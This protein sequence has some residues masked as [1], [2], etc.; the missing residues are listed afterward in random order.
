MSQKAA[1]TCYI[2]VNGNQL[3]YS[4]KIE[5]PLTDVKRESIVPGFFKETEMVPYVK[6]D[7]VADPSLNYESLK[8][9]G[10]TIT[11][12]FDNSRTYVLSDAYLTGEPNIND[13]GVVSLQFDGRIGTFQ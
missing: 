8:Q 7:I 6:C 9:V 12:D 3:I 1:G 11:V 4:G 13:E 10:V 5:V 2:S